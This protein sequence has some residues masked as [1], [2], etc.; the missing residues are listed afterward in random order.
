MSLFEVSSTSCSILEARSP[1]TTR[2]IYERTSMRCKKEQR[3]KIPTHPHFRVYSPTEASSPSSRAENNLS[4]RF[5]ALHVVTTTISSR[6]FRLLF[7]FS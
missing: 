1:S 7:P 6:K 5:A 2:W 4:R 3:S